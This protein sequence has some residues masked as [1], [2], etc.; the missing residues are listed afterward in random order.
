[1]ITPFR[2]RSRRFVAVSVRLGL[3]QRRG[4]GARCELAHSTNTRKVFAAR[5]ERVLRTAGRCST[6]RYARGT[7]ATG[8]ESVDGELSNPPPISRGVGAV[9]PRPSVWGEARRALAHTTTTRQ[10]RAARRVLH[11]PSADTQWCDMRAGHAP[12]KLNTRMMAYQTPAA[13]QLRSRCGRAST[14]GVWRSSPR[15]GPQHNH[16]PSLRKCTKRIDSRSTRV[17]ANILSVEPWTAVYLEVPLG[18]GNHLARRSW[19]RAVTTTRTFGHTDGGQMGRTDRRRVRAPAANARPSQLQSCPACAL[20]V[21]FPSPHQQ[22]PLM[23][24]A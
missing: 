19:P 1:M 3:G 14:D 18:G 17:V 6:V 4:D 21:L 13:D 12:Q 8:V 11:A 16:A 22:A 20:P 5:A 15:I 7:R 2:S 9:E 10:V 24:N 23:A